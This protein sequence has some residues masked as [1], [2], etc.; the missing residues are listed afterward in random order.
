MKMPFGRFKGELIEDI[1]TDY[2]EWL[3][4]ETDIA[5]RNPKLAD[6][7]DA[8][9]RLKSGEGVQRKKGELG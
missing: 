8:Q 3:L 6:E 4:R 2:L 5:D 9:I 1:P 7:A